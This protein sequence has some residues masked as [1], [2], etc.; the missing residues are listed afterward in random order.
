[1]TTRYEDT[2]KLYFDEERLPDGTFLMVEI[3][4]KVRYEIEQAYGL[5]PST[6]TARVESR[7]ITDRHR[8]SENGDDLPDLTDEEIFQ[9]LD[10][11]SRYD[12]SAM[13]LEA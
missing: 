3:E 4:F 7:A 13:L 12:I 2:K 11:D 10:N 1:M 8:Y 5:Q 9:W 6:A